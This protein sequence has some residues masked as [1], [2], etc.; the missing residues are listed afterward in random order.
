MKSLRSISLLIL[1]GVFL[2]LNGRTCLPCLCTLLYH[3][4]IPEDHEHGFPNESRSACLFDQYQV[5]EKSDDHTHLCL[6]PESHSRLVPV[7][8]VLSKTIVCSIKSY[9]AESPPGPTL[10]E[11]Q[12]IDSVVKLRRWL[13][14]CESFSIRFI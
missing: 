1:L 12:I 13:N 10:L 9:K 11:D 5:E 14:I 2:C 4:F 3:Q 8:E 6:S 7:A